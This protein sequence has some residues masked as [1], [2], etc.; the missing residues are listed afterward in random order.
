MA[1]VSKWT[2]FGVALDL[3]AT[4]G[5]VTR[6]SATQ[7]TVKIN[8]SWET[9]YS[10][11]QTNY[12]MMAASGGVTYIIS[13]FDGTKRSSGSASFTGT[14]SISGNGSATKTV[15]VTFKN[16]NAD[17]GDI[18]SKDVTFNVTVPAWTSYTIKYNANGGSGAPSSQTKWKDQ[19]LKLSTTKPTRTGYSFLGWSTSSSATTA[20]YAAGANYTANAGATLY[21]VWKANTYTVSYNANGGTGA[22]G[23]QTK[24]YGVSLKLSSTK[25]TRTNYNFKGWGT[26]ASATT[27]TYAAGANYTNNAA[28]TLY[29][30]WEIAYIKPRISNLSIARCDPTGATND[31]GQN[32]LVRF[33]WESDQDISSVAI[34]WK[35]PSETSWTSVTVD[36][37]FS[38][39]LIF[40]GNIDGK[41]TV[42]GEFVKVSDLIP[43]EDDF[44][45]GFT[46]TFN[47]GPETYTAD[48]VEWDQQGL[49]LLGGD[50]IIIRTTDS[51]QPIQGL[52]WP[53]TGIYFSYTGGLQS[54]TIPGYARFPVASDI[55]LFD[56]NTEGKVVYDE[57][58]VKVSDSVPLQADFTNGLSK[59]T[60]GYFGDVVPADYLEVG[61]GYIAD[62]DYFFVVITG[63][64]VQFFRDTLNPEP[65]VYFNMDENMT[66]LRIPGYSGFAPSDVS[67]TSGSVK[68]V[69]GYNALS[70]ESSYDVH[71]T[72]TDSGGSS[73]ATGTLTSMR[74]VIDV[75]AEGK[76]IAF[77]KTSE[78]EDTAEFAFDAK[79]NRPVYGKALGMDR[80][81]AI[82]GNSDFN[83]YIEPGCYAVYSNAV[84]ATCA[85]I[86]TARAGRLEVWS[87]TGEG[88]RSEQYS[89]IRQRFVPYNR[90]NAVW[91][92]DVTRGSNNVWSYGEWWKSSLT[93]AASA[94]V[95]DEPVTLF[96]GNSTGAITLSQSPDN[97]AYL[98]IFF[99]DNNGEKGGYTKLH[100][101]YTSVIDLWIV[102]AG[103]SNI[104][105]VRR[106]YYT[107]SGTT[108]TP[109]TTTAGYVRIVGS[110][111]SHTVGTNYI[112]I[113]KVLGRNS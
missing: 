86:P 46:L 40:D 75:L 2:P 79:F 92:R 101:P 97:F 19:T 106:T 55:L 111:V 91:E 4:G 20:T 3:T 1:T 67:G 73:Y 93:P 66:G 31:E 68:Q 34:K 5:T 80:L 89:Y 59:K 51:G 112:K 56:G 37:R 24:T 105:F 32:G 84:A 13:K 39:T 43:T 78:L 14:Y 102:E 27:V 10:G 22:P 110:T 64:N 98:E 41:V 58:Y 94:R 44:A 107:I 83:S 90:E 62:G 30:I 11:A 81:P 100:S 38:D 25:P 26:S 72:V 71:V 54:L 23:N 21:A 6:T 104:T 60:S 29:A 99:T 70:S 47:T 57:F 76:G 88:I 36:D 48:E 82:P 87:S 109:N 53:E 12:G 45:N 103:D 8:V 113:T 108:M 16:Y 15:T 96:S 17:N 63:S 42:D 7:Y 18:A 77:G 49:L 50:V 74:F 52:E 9:Y 65:G 61:Q 33:D 69:I 28:I 35:L 95:Y 85:N